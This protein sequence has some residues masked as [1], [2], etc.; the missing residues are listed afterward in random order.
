MI[1]VTGATG[2]VGRRVVSLLSVPHRSIVRDAS[3]AVGEY[4]VA[5]DYG[6]LGE[7][8]AAFEGADTVFLVPAAENADR[9][10][11][12]VTAV[13]AAVAAGVSRLVYLSFL[14]ASADATFT[15][16]RDHW[17]TEQHIRSTALRWTFLRMNLYMDFIPSMVGADGVIRGPAG[18]GRVSAILRSDVA[19][20]AAAVLLGDG[21][22]D[23]H[24]GATY[25]LTGPSS[26]SLSEAAALMGARFEDETDDEA[27]A[28]RAGYGAP[29]WEVRGWV[30]S[31]Q[32]IR[33]GSLAAVS[34]AVRELTGR[35][36]LSLA[37]HLR[38]R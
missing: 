28:S 38:A 20:T 3:R 11:Q 12:H 25:D 35:D 4:R 19:A 32:A 36:P 22:G 7:M 23:G 8:T 34:P 1:A 9:V 24:D 18:D 10:A 33:D 37:E 27:Y 13:D 31:Y 15:L 17:A 5:S 26:F 29:D 21:D 16:A 30:T 2:E 6:A 14:G